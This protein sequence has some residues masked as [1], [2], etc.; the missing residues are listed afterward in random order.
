MKRFA[1]LVLGAGL[2]LGCQKDDI[3]FVKADSEIGRLVQEQAPA[4][5]RFPFALNQPQSLRT[6]GGAT[7]SFPANSFRLP[8]GQT[9]ATGQAELRVRENYAVP[10]MLL[11][12]MPTTALHGQ[13][14]ISGGEFNIQVWQGTT[15]LRLP[16]SAGTAS[17]GPGLAL[18]SPIPT[19]G[20]D[21]TRMQLWQQPT[22]TFAPAGI[23]SSGWRPVGATVRVTAAGQYTVTLPL[24]SIGNWNIDQFW[25]A[26]QH[27][28]TVNAA[29]EVPAGASET[30]VYFRPVGYNGLARA[31]SSSSVVAST[32]FTSLLPLG[33]AV[34][35]VVLQ[36]REGQLYYG[37]Q[38]VTT[39]AGQVI[40]PVLEPLAEAEIIRRIRLL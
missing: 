19:A 18:S 37:T 29:V 4:T 11:A 30:R 17:G 3:L 24:D 40:Q 16:P 25:H 34:V 39:Q 2:L 23:D 26:Y 32:R 35:A 14:L 1:L 8:D 10:D 20:L 38:T 5:Q 21:T 33:A 12:D 36:A 7:L 6:A 13:L 22:R 28:G 27:N 31:R 9:L 15:R